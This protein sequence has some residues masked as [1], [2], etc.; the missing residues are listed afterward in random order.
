M[1]QNDTS[2]RLDYIDS[3]NSLWWGNPSGGA[4]LQTFTGQGYRCFLPNPGSSGSL[5][6]GRT[7]IKVD[8]IRPFVRNVTAADGTHASGETVTVRVNFNEDV[9]VVQGSEPVLTLNFT[10]GPENATFSSGNGSRQLEFTRVLG[11]GDNAARLDYNGTGALQGGTIKDGAGNDWNM[12]L[13]APGEPGSLGRTSNVKTDTDAPIVTSVESPTQSGTYGIGD[14]IQINV[15]FNEDVAVTGAPRH[16]A[17]CG[18][19]QQVRRVRH[20]G[21]DRGGRLGVHVRGRGGRHVR[22]PGL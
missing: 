9:F 7:T 3:Q 10:G 19:D 2:D 13:A 17:R 12:R 18:R 16:S 6:D 1:Q 21:V 14:S 20:D 5:S 4:D 8:G 15:E 11:T 22:R